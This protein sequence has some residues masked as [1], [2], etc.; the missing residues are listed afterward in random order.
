MTFLIARSDYPDKDFKILSKVFTDPDKSCEDPSIWYDYK[1]ERFYAAAKYY[2]NKGAIIS[3]FGALA[4]I[5]SKNG[6][7]WEVAKNP[8]ISLRQLLMKDGKTM[9]L[10]NMERPFVY[11]DEEGQPLALFSAFSIVKQGSY[12]VENYT[13]DCNTGNVGIKLNSITK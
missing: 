2:S 9:E 3:Q 11:T 8:L 4:L 6:T 10:A 1:R 5:T 7:D 12:K 13:P